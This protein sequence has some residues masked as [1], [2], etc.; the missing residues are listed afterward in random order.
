MSSLPEFPSI[1]AALSHWAQRRPDAVAFTFVQAGGAIEQ[2]TYAQLE[3]NALRVALSLRESTRPGDRALLILPPGLDFLTAFLGCLHSGV[4]AVPLYPP[5]PGARLDRI[6][7]VVRSCQPA[8]AVTTDLFVEQLT[9]FFGGNATASMRIHPFKSL[10]HDEP[11]SAGVAAVRPGPGGEDLAFLQYTSGS[12]GQPKGVMV[13]HRNLVQNEEAIAEGF[14]IR[15]DDTVLSWLPMYHDMG[16]I[17]TALLPVYRGIP[18][19]LLD[20]FAFVHD[21]MLWP[22]AVDRFGATCSGGP[23]FAYQLLVER[24]DRARLTDIDLS[25][26]RIAFNGAEPVR[27]ET[28]RDFATCYG[29]HGFDRDAFFPCYGLAEATLF[30]AGAEPGTGYRS[31][32]VSR[33]ELER[34]R[35]VEL[36]E[37]TSEAGTS[38][39]SS[40]RPA[41]HTEIVI[42]GGDDDRVLPDGEIGEIC[43][44]GPGVAQGYWDDATATRQTFHADVPGREGRYLRTGDLGFTWQGELYPVSRSKDLLIVAG[45][46]FYPHDVETVALTACADLRGGAAAAFQPDPDAPP[47]TLVAEVARASLARLRDPAAAAAVRTEVL[48]AVGVECDLQL[49][50]VVLVY[51]GSLPKTSS[52]KIRRSETRARHLTGRLRVLGHSE[53]PQ[54]RPAPPTADQLDALHRRDRDTRRQLVRQLLA[55]LVSAAGQ[56]LTV[57]D[58]SRPL[59]ALGLDSLRTATVKV[60]CEQQLGRSLDSRLFTSDRSLEE[61]AEAVV[62]LTGQPPEPAQPEP[63]T[64]SPDRVAPA[65]DG[66]VQMQFYDEFHPQDTANNLTSAVRLSRGYD[67]DLLRAAVSAAVARHPALR[68]VLG[69]PG[70]GTQIVRDSPQLDWSQVALTDIDES[71]DS[72]LREVA[73]RRFCLTEGPLVRAAA[74]LTPETTVFM[75]VCHHA[76]VDH[77][78]LRVIFMEI[79]AELPGVRLGGELPATDRGDYVQ[80]QRWLSA[81]TDDESARRR[82]TALAERWH[83]LR[84]H[85]LFPAVRTG[86]TPGRNPA[87]TIDF[88]VDGAD[89]LYQRAQLRGHTPFVSLVA[90]YLRALHRTTGEQRI[91][92]GTPHHGRDDWR[93]ADTVGYLV[94][95]LPLAGRFEG[96]ERPEQIEDRSRAELRDALADADLPFARLVKALSPERHGQTP[97]FQATFTFQQSTDGLLDDGFSIPSSGCRQR[98]GEVEVSVVDVPPRDVAFTVSLYG[99]RH[100]DRLTFRLV[101]QRERIDAATAARIVAE[102]QSALKEI[103]SPGPAPAVEEA[104]R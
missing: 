77:W 51:P 12:T 104:G 66:Q 16:L 56:Q 60:R 68:T 90:A 91:V 15:P 96:E 23:N 62:V 44:R 24:Y 54:P 1:P 82:L 70:S 80:R 8:H 86:G 63:T 94:N 53:N 3:E 103:A 43:V 11:G 25:R 46:N 14:G 13:S 79:L 10:L 61:I 74:V 97:L 28:M 40:G 26:W 92:I 45:R 75:L 71:V 102:F 37:E 41:R 21:P 95:M 39:V 58:W 2:V 48:R 38:L 67:P 50:E 55:A 49:A 93:F 27:A 69:S 84:D 65:T 72:F 101:Y 34:G 22:L 7:S 100:A 59:A 20:T 76:I 88:E 35:L 4:V 29:V 83:P 31:R 78:S 18:S 98:L 52:G 47:V 9:A 36:P 57:Q 89:R 87:A 6:E 19:V 73:D 85:L 17:G 81:S 42:R 5:R 30:V 32:Q 64:G 99:T 33:R